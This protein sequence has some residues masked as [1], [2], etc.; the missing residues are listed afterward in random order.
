MDTLNTARPAGR[1]GRRVVELLL[2]VVFLTVIGAAA[3]Y[4]VGHKVR[5]TRTG[6][7][8]T[9]ETPTGAATTTGAASA[10]KTCLDVTERDAK[11]RFRSPGGLV[12][13][14]Y[15]R[16]AKSEVWICRD[17]AD[18]LFYQGHLLAA[19][20][21]PG[22]RAP[23]TDDNSL[24]LQTVSRDGTGYVAENSDGNGTTRYRVSAA[25]LVIEYPDGRTERQDAVA[26]E[27]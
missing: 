8:A 14:L 13:V 21:Q 9:E 22:N 11:S 3:G 24:I 1:G 2:A 16:T 5:E 19:G 25:R 17:K 27:S 10:T 7:P 4:V 23:F 6:G 12:Q 26:H 20:E 18:N 15:I